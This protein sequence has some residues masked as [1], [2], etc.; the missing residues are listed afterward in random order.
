MNFTGYKTS[1]SNDNN[2][3][4]IYDN[5]T[6]DVRNNIISGTTCDGHDKVLYIATIYVDNVGT[7]PIGIEV[8]VT[9]QGM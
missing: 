9:R 4:R 7:Y 1:N 3:N 6:F 8:S 5:N 2:E